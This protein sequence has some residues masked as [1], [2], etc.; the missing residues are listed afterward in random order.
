MIAPGDRA[1]N[2][3]HQL[4]GWRTGI[5]TRLCELPRLPGEPDVFSFAGIMCDLSR[6]GRPAGATSCGGVGLSRKDALLCCLGEAVERYC[7][8]FVPENLELSSY[9]DTLPDAVDPTAFSLFSDEQYAFD[10]FPFAPACHDTPLHW[11]EA[12]SLTERKTKL[13]P[14]SMVYMPYRQKE[15]EPLVA[16]TTSTGLCCATDLDSAALGGLLEV[17]ERDALAIMWLKGAG[18][19]ELSDLPEA[20]L[21]PFHSDNIE[22]RVYDLTSDVGICVYLVL[23]S[24]NSDCG[25]LITVGAAAGLEPTAVLSR[26]LLENVQG[27]FALMSMQH[28]DPDWRPK[29]DFTNILTFHDHARVLTCRPELLEELAFLGARGTRPF[30]ATPVC[31]VGSKGDELSWCVD[32]LAKLGLEVL[33]KDITTPDVAPLGLRVVRV[34]VPGMQPLHGA[35]PLP[36]LGGR[37]LE[38]AAEIFGISP[39]DIL[40]PDCFSPI[41]HP[42]P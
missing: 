36:F 33:V 29:T 20:L 4:V 12:K 10:G 3:Y 16:P 21:R 8:Q 18:V 34:L 25:R 13:V 28:S 19:W 39:E 27:R 2:L 42:L 31:P 5:I 40:P 30:M 22:Y 26:A 9:Q 6:L 37:R 17:I 14:A 11:T 41:P 24:G 1:A 32:R 38:R 23:S 35:H 7:C 15:G